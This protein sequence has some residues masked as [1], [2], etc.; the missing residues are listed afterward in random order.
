MRLLDTLRAVTVYRYPEYL[1][2]VREARSALAGAGVSTSVDDLAYA[3]WCERRHPSAQQ[4]GGWQR[5]LRQAQANR[6]WKAAIAAF[7]AAGTKLTSSQKKELGELGAKVDGLEKELARA[8]SLER[9]DPEPAAEI[10]LAVAAQWS[11]PRASAALLRCPPAPASQVRARKERGRVVVTWAAS[12]A[13][14]GALSYDVVRSSGHRPAHIDDGVR[15]LSGSTALTVVDSAPPAAQPLHYAVFVTRESLAVSPPATS[16]AVVIL[17][18]VEDLALRPGADLI[19]GRYRAPS[20]AA[21]VEVTRTRSGGGRAVQVPSAR[22][23]GF[24]DRDVR[25][26]ERYE[27]R[28]RVRYRLPDGSSACTEGLRD[29]AGCQE[30]PQPVTDLQVVFQGGEIE[31]SWTP[32][33]AGQVEVLELLD[34]AVLASPGVR[35]WSA[36]QKL[37]RPLSDVSLHTRN[38][39]R[40]CPAATGRQVRLVPVTV[41]GDLAAV[42]PLR[43]MDRGLHPVTQLRAVRRGRFVQLLWVWPDGVGEAR[44]LASQQQKPTDP[45]DSSVLAKDV[46]R[47]AYDISGVRLPFKGVGVH[48]FAVCTVTRTGG[49]ISYGPLVTVSESAVTEVTYRISGAGMSARP[50]PHPDRRRRGRPYLAGYGA[51]REVEN[52]SAVADRWHRGDPTGR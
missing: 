31:V 48:H 15:L 28:V 52:P 50:A 18:D 37:G 3:V 36:V 26:G 41:L 44:V 14:A 42:G 13:L 46:T 49:K 10:Y 22:L 33:L 29:E 6:D 32:P 20:G 39:I 21:S 4:T 27:Y 11:D 5:D 51:R 12:P 9:S 17:P 2:Q 34:P 16:D 43:T 1:Q 7:D 25:A 30:V 24:T 19:S 23:D 47:A 45:Q 35:P 40:A 38:R 8:A